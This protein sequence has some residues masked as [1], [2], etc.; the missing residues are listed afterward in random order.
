MRNVKERD[1]WIT[2]FTPNWSTAVK[3]SIEFMTDVI[4]SRSGREQRHSI[5]QVPR[6][7]IEFSASMTQARLQVLRA[8]IAHRQ[9]QQFAAKTP[10]RSIR[11]AQSADEGDTVIEVEDVPFWVQPMT[12]LVLED[13]TSKSLVTVQS[14]NG[15]D[16]TLD[17]PLSFDFNAAHC[18]VHETAWYRL[19]DEIQFS[20]PI[21]NLITVGIQLERVPD[22]Q[23]VIFKPQNR[24][25]Y[26]GYDLWFETPNWSSTPSIT[27]GRER[28]TF[29]PGIHRNDVFEPNA[30]SQ[31]TYGFSRYALDAEKAEDAIGFFADKLGRRTAFWAPELLKTFDILGRIGNQRIR[32]P[33]TDFRLAFEG[34]AVYDRMIHL[35]PDGTYQINRVIEYETDNDETIVRFQN[36][37]Q[38]QIGPQ[39]KVRWLVL[40]RFAADQITPEWP[41]TTV[42]KIQMAMA[43]LRS[44]EATP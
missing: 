2:T 5:R 39:S 34:D 27:I 4:R 30:Y 18:R 24:P 40:K 29:D 14:V 9:G 38:Q 10:W 37:W 21:D 35:R 28:E 41:T 12:K 25:Q 13:L 7:G 36:N 3:C 19:P 33:G 43:S 1:A 32:V 15:N 16:V 20:T 22:E 31:M 6:I 26:L 11:L 23:P 8:E 42:S 44:D 17:A